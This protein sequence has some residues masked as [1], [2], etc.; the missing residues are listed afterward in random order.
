MNDLFCAHPLCHKNHYHSDQ[1]KIL[2]KRVAQAANH[3]VP[4]DSVGL[5]V[6]NA[7]DLAKV[8]V[9]PGVRLNSSDSHNHV[10]HKLHSLVVEN[11]FLLLQGLGRQG[12]Y[13]LATNADQPHYESTDYVEPI[14]A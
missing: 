6:A 8:V 11:G 10:I 14:R 4:Q 7:N 1:P 5:H 12:C 13:E 3:V 2:E 9:F